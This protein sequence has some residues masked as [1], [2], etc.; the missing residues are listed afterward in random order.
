[1]NTVLVDWID[2]QADSI[3]SYIITIFFS[4]VR[5]GVSQYEIRTAPREPLYY[6]MLPKNIELCWSPSCVLVDSLMSEECVIQ[7]LIGAIINCYSRATQIFSTSG[8]TAESRNALAKVHVRIFGYQNIQ[9]WFQ[10]CYVRQPK[11]M[12][13]HP[14]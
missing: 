11:I 8:P 5:E 13:D 3:N 14:G 9:F 10:Y 2:L 7:P 12:A 1:M 4:F 6:E